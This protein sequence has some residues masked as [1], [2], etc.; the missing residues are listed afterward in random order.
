MSENRTGN[1]RTLRRVLYRRITGACLQAGAHLTLG[2]VLVCVKHLSGRRERVIHLCVAVVVVV[3]VIVVVVVAR[4]DSLY[5]LFSVA[6]QNLHQNV[7]IFSSF[8]GSAV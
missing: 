8:C 5:S 4:V 2:H 7:L 3:V 1:T 6:G